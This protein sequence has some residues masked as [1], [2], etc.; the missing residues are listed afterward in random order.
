[1]SRRRFPHGAVLSFF[2]G[3]PLTAVLSFITPRI[4]QLFEFR[5][6]FFVAGDVAVLSNR[7]L[8]CFERTLERGDDFAKLRGVQP[9]GISLKRH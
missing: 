7:V 1:M 9:I 3:V 4:D 8:A 2:A 6:G 5:D